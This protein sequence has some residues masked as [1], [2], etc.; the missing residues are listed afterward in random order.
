MSPR[1]K[2]SK[3]KKT[4]VALVILGLLASIAAAVFFKQF[5]YDAS[6]YA[7]SIGNAGQSA[8]GLSWHIPETMGESL[9]ILNEPES[10]GPEDLFNK[11]DGKAELYLSAGFAELSCQRFSEKNNPESWAEIYIYNMAEPRNAFAVFSSQ[12]RQKATDIDIGD[13][14]YEARGALFFTH[15]EFYVEVIPSSESK[16]LG[17]AMSAV[18]RDFVNNTQAAHQNL[19][20]LQIFPHTNL[21]PGSITLL[22]KNAFGFDRLDNVFTAVYKFNTEEVTAF[23]SLRRDNYEAKELLEAYQR[24]LMANGANERQAPNDIPGAKLMELFGTYELVF[25]NGP[26]LAGVHQAANAQAAENLARILS[27]GLLETN[28]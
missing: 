20:E 24:F 18:A 4:I 9:A 25:T 21:Q 12:R 27:A 26:Y 3:G 8:Q 15:G 19:P 22:S 23:L 17:K 7:P 13:F 5:Y 28:K 1:N 10:F 6:I 16:T 11:I 14:G 2:P